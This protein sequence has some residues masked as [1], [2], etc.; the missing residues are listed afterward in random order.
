MK[1]IRA[2]NQF[3]KIIDKYQNSLK[4]IKVKYTLNSLFVKDLNQIKNYNNFSDE[5]EY[6]INEIKNENKIKNDKIFN[7]N[8]NNNSN[9]PNVNLSNEKISKDIFFYYRNKL[10][11]KEINNKIINKKIN[12]RYNSANKRINSGKKSVDS[13]NSKNSNRR[14]SNA[15]LILPLIYSRNYNTKRTLNYNNKS[16]TSDDDTTN[17]ISFHQS[18][19]NIKTLPSDEIENEINTNSKK[20]EKNILSKFTKKD[21]NKLN[22]NNFYRL[23][24]KDILKNLRMK[25]AEKELFCKLNLPLI[26]NDIFNKINNVA[27]KSENITKNINYIS[28]EG[29]IA[30]ENEKNRIKFLKEIV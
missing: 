6:I 27:K 1:M 13:F 21:N 14:K 8:N 4:N 26:E 22:E 2:T 20:K 5:E 12:F 17:I 9:F 3:Q 28:T 10:D 15:S 29:N 18:D 7:N 24:I 30:F 25:K 11:K 23:N 19:K 16:F